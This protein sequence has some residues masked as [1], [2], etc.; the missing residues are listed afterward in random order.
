ML[1][2][3]LADDQPFKYPEEYQLFD[4][5]TEKAFKKNFVKERYVPKVPDPDAEAKQL[6]YFQQKDEAEHQGALRVRGQEVKKIQAL[7][8]FLQ[9]KALEY[10][11]WRKK[12]GNAAP[13]DKRTQRDYLAEIYAEMLKEHGEVA[14]ARF[15]HHAHLVFGA[16]IKQSETMA[17]SYP[18]EFKN[19]FYKLVNACVQVGKGKVKFA[20]VP[21]SLLMMVGAR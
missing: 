16:D 1:K 17:K 13:E 12:R 2:N 7:E 14:K 10:N 18:T 9:Q 3:E 20:K 8:R 19:Y 6:E 11:E 5:A 21:P 15:P 4:D